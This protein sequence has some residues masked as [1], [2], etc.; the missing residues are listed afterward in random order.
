M[1]QVSGGFPQ[2]PH[3]HYHHLYVLRVLG[4]VARSGLNITIQKFLWRASWV[5]L[6][7]LLVLS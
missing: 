1:I 5:R 3:H 7:F 6:S 2:S 4:L